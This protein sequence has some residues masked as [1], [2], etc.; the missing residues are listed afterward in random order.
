MR[1]LHAADVD[2]AVSLFLRE[3]TVLAAPMTDLLQHGPG[4]AVWRPVRDP[5]RRVGW[6]EQLVP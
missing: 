1:A 5:D 2:L 3:V 4:A 6:M